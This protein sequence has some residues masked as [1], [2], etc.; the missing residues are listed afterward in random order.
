MSRA[1]RRARAVSFSSCT[2]SIMS[3]SVPSI[4]SAASEAAACS[5]KY[6]EN[7]RVGADCAQQHVERGLADNGHGA[8][9]RHDAIG[10]EFGEHRVA[11]FPAGL[12]AKVGLLL[13]VGA[14]IAGL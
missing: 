7:V 2:P 8:H 9:R 4:A 13:K 14:Q 12:G 3:S 6:V 11:Q 5:T 1:A 10:A